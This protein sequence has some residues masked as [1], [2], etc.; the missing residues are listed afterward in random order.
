[1]VERDK[2]HQWDRISD[3][4]IFR[5]RDRL[6]SH[7]NPYGRGPKRDSVAGRRARSALERPYY[8][9]LKG[10]TKKRGEALCRSV[11]RRPPR[12]I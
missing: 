9:Q 11:I 1:M 2:R 3:H 10:L 7:G 6:G 8:E 5:D 12:K 4:R